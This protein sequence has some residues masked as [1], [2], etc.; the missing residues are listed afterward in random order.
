MHWATEDTW[1][2]WRSKR[3]V[4]TEI[5][6]HLMCTSQL[7]EKITPVGVIPEK[8]M[9]E[10]KLPFGLSQYITRGWGPHVNCC[11]VLSSRCGAERL[12]TICQLC[13]NRHIALP[14]CTGAGPH[15]KA[16]RHCLCNRGD[17]ATA[18]SSYH[19]TR[20]R[21]NSIT[22]WKSSISSDKM[23]GVQHV[24]GRITG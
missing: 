10:P 4:G 18:K 20:Q 17:L 22:K 15:H 24:A 11:N 5:S 9:V 6:A 23:K 12:S 3:H 19:N 16:D 14:K 8:L 2:V 7:K 13:C 1:S 21:A